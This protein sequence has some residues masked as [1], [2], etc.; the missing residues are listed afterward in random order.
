M[1]TRLVANNFKRFDTL[2]VELGSPVVFVGPN[3]SG[4]TTALQALALWSVCLSRWSEKRGEGNPPAKRPGV[5]INRNDLFPIPVPEA[6]HLWHGTHIRERTK[7]IRI[8]LIVYGV[9]D[10]EE[11]ECGLELDYTNEQSFYCRPLRL[12]EDKD[13]ERMEIPGHAKD[14]KIAYLPPMSG[15]TGTE[16]RLDPGAINVRIGEGRTAEVLRNLC[17]SLHDGE[18]G[19]ARWTRLVEQIN[20]LFGVKLDPPLYVRERGEVQM[21]YVNRDGTRLDLSSSGR[22]L[23]QTLLLMSYLMT[24]RGAVLLLDEPDAHLEILRQRQIYQ[25]L[26]EVAS[27]EGCQIVAASHSEVILNEA[28]DRDVVIAFV[29]KP[30]RIDDRGSQTAK[31]LKAVGFDQ[32]FQ[33]EQTGWV[34]YLEGST[35]LACLVAFAELLGHPATEVLARPFVKYVANLPSQAYDH[36]YALREARPDLLGFALYD[37][38]KSQ[39]EKREG[40][41]QHAWSKREIE[42]YLCTRD[43]LI[44]WTEEMSNDQLGPLFVEGAVRTMEESISEL[45]QALQTL[46]QPSPWSDDVK[47][48]DVF[49]DP[50]FESFFGKLH[51]SNL[52]RK[53]DYHQ[54]ARL[55]KPDEIDQEVVDVLDEIVAVAGA[56]TGPPAP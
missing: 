49:L 12:S 7:N 33:A 44:R 52:M 41:T 10:G 45:E 55:L 43:V 5:T 6:N 16:T 31:A 13:P 23:Q 53:S 8:D 14:A 48:T 21:S 4:K 46:K 20:E 39:P 15:L 19:A 18:D 32:Y 36:Y 51:L 22:G 29:G 28:A 50:L 24:N 27:A 2:D 35:D 25:A 11:W 42:N 1:L 56:A 38:L 3:D 17:L 37:R 54:L 26:T 47:A 40:L 34:L 30:H 9:T